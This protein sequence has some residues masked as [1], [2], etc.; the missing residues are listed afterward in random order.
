MTANN[1]TRLWTHRWFLSQTSTIPKPGSAPIPIPIGV[2]L[3]HAVVPPHRGLAD[4]GH[5]PR[6]EVEDCDAVYQGEEE[7]RWE[8]LGATWDVRQLLLRHGS[9]GQL[10]DDVLIRVAGSE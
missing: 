5:D 10:P 9:S 2:V 4:D 8:G 6:C 7:V 1:E 3:V